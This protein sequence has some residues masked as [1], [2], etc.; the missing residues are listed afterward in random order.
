MITTR[1][2]RKETTYMNKYE[3]PLPFGTDYGDFDSFLEAKDLPKGE[4]QT[5]REKKANQTANV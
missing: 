5:E 2:L 4:K 3:Y 1:T